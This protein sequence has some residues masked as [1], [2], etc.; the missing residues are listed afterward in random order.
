M[1]KILFHW[2]KKNMDY[3]PAFKLCFNFKVDIAK[4]DIRELWK[5]AAKRRN[6]TTTLIRTKPPPSLG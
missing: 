5:A 4:C 3:D 1:H 2:H 6:K